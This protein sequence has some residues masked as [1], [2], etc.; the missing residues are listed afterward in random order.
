MQDRRQ[1]LFSASAAAI[2]AAAATEAWAAKVPL[3][4]G[5]REANML[6]VSSPAVYE[7]A[8]SIPGLSGIEVQTVRSKLWEREN[9]LAYKRES[10]RWR[11]RTASMG[12]TLP[13]GQSITVPGP[14]E[15]SLRKTIKAAE[16]L[17]ASVVMVAGFRETCPKMDDEA[18]YGP[19][20]EMLKRLAPTAED[21]GITLAL[22]TSLTTDEHIKLLNLVNLPAVRVYWD[23]TGTESMVH[24]GE[25]LKGFETL[26][27]RICQIHLKNGNKLME[28]PNLVDW[29]KAF[30]AIKKLNFEGWFVFETSHASPEA[31]VADT[32]RNI[33][34][35]MKGLGE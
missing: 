7:M 18:S 22:L 9:V 29:T 23:G 2:T 19:V 25:G 5:H 27:D 10:N 6:R 3:K 24:N 21:A 16:I 26:G 35:L 30:P 11:I 33:E 14:A 17:G 1:F 4:V 13:A 12:G 34:W 32:R 20:V 31:C 28:E 8:A 15:E